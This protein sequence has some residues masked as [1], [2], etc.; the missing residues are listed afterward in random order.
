MNTGFLLLLPTVVFVGVGCGLDPSATRPPDG[1][2]VSS[3]GPA[4]GPTCDEIWIEETNL[5]GDGRDYDGCY[6]VEQGTWVHEADYTD[7]YMDP[8]DPEQTIQVRLWEHTNPTTGVL[9]YAF[10]GGNG[11]SAN[12]GLIDNGDSIGTWS[13]TP[14]IETARRICAEG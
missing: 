1:P 2:E 3:L 11:G 8:L 4:P 13:G 10:T 9:L 6:Q 12:N 7:C 5:P 14:V